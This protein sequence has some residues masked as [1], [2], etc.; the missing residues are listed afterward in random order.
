MYFLAK[1]IG[2]V[3]GFIFEFTGNYGLSIILLTIL[4]KLL[5]FPLSIKQVKSTNKIS[6]LQPQL[7]K[8]QEK[9]K[10]DKE[11]L[12]KKTMELY[13]ENGAN[14]LSGCLPLLIQMPILFGLF[15]V[16]RM[17]E[18]YVFSGNIEAANLAVQ[19]SFLWL[20][21]LSEPDLIGNVL[22]SGPSWLLALP[23]V[24]P[25]ISSISTYFSMSMNGSAQ[26]GGNQMK[27]FSLMTPLMI[28]YMGANFA[29]GLM[30]YW[31]VSNVFQI[32]QQVLIP[33]LTK[34]D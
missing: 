1:F 10:D 16:L 12:N 29:S 24:F 3:L 30:L 31:T 6:K 11:T 21:S 8:L 18:T 7:K 15:G 32:G 19:T 20:K 27:M 26:Q 22:A 2:P 25:I 28:L 34:E 13:S 9:Y 4:I 5:L 33:K 23:G 17:P 14:P